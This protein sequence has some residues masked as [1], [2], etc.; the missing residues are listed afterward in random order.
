MKDLCSELGFGFFEDNIDNY[1]N[2]DS[3]AKDSL[4]SEEDLF[5]N[6][7]ELDKNGELIEGFLPDLPNDLDEDIENLMTFEEDPIGH[8]MQN[9]VALGGAFIDIMSDDQQTIDDKNQTQYV[10]MKQ[11]MNSSK[12]HNANG[13][14]QIPL[15][16]FEQ[17]IN[18]VISGKKSLK[19]D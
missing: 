2:D 17:F 11:V 4:C 19:D 5:N 7:L 10:S 13:R 9:I 6:N 18:D 12:G 14:P 1:Y 15:R 8:S 3:F 16:P